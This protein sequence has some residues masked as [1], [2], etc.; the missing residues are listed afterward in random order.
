MR[1]RCG[2]T[3]GWT[4]RT[5]LAWLTPDLVCNLTG[6]GGGVP[7]GGVCATAR[8][9][10]I[11]THLEQLRLLSTLATQVTETAVFVL[12]EIPWCAKLD[13]LA[14]IKNKNSSRAWSA[15]ILLCFRDMSRVC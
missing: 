8:Y 1:S 4:V 6:T 9:P 12:K 10:T 2:R 7:W 11:V 13:D 15:S 3:Q 5:W 14:V